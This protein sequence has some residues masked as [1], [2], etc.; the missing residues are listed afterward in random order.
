[1]FQPNSAQVIGM[2]D[3]RQPMRGDQL[4]LRTND[5]WLSVEP[6]LTNREIGS[7]AKDVLPTRFRITDHAEVHPAFTY[8]SIA[9]ATA[10]A[11]LWSVPK[12]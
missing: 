6:G 7:S 10:T 4:A 11:A 9:A 5:R 12:K 1:M 3:Q 8:F 2:Q